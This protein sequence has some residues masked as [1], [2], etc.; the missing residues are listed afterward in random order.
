MK[1]VWEWLTT[2]GWK[3]LGIVLLGILI[4]PVLAYQEMQ[5]RLERER[6]ESLL[7][8]DPSVPEVF[9]LISAVDQWGQIVYQ[10]GTKIRRDAFGVAVMTWEDHQKNKAALSST[11]R[12]F[13]EDEFPAVVFFNASGFDNSGAPLVVRK[14]A[15]GEIVYDY[16]EHGRTRLA[17]VVMV[18]PLRDGK[19]VEV[20][21]HAETPG[22]F[23]FLTLTTEAWER[24]YLAEPPL[25]VEPKSGIQGRVVRI[26]GIVRAVDPLVATLKVFEGRTDPAKPGKVLAEIQSSKDGGTFKVALPAGTYTLAV[27][28]DGKL[29]GNSVDPNVWP[30]VDVPANTWVDYEFRRGP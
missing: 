13:S 10:D 11:Q 28:E 17:P 5:K 25:P 4:V 29:Y 20:L 19:H 2:W 9:L 16:G 27:E 14:A 7:L 23:M 3:K 8:L 6:A 26:G 21:I 1:V 12:A 30:S 24:D 22:R 15:N 18:K